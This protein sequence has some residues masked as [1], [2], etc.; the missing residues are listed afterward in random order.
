MFSINESRQTTVG[1]ETP[2]KNQKMT[3]CVPIQLNSNEMR[4][5]QLC[6]DTEPQTQCFGTSGGGKDYAGAG[7]SYPLAKP[8]L[9]SDLARK[10]HAGR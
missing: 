4:W 10:I 6:T 7:R 1:E 3:V 9:A 5:N 2:N 8:G